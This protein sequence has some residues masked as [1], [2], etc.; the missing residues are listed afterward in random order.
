MAT[1]LRSRLQSTMSS[2]PSASPTIS[3]DKY[4]LPTNAK[5]CHYDLTLWTDLESLEFGGF[6][7]VDLD[8]LQETSTIV[9]NCSNDLKLGT[10]SVYCGALDVDQKLQSAQ[11]AADKELERVTLNFFTALPA[12][13]KAQVKIYYSAMLRGSMNGYY[14]SAW[15]RD[16]KTEYY[17]L[18]H[19][20]PTDARAAFPCW[21]EPL[22]KATWTITMISRS[23]TVN[24][25]NMPAES[26]QAWDSSSALE[27]NL[28][29]LLSTLPKKDVLGKITKFQKTPPMSS[30]LVAFANGPFAH[31]ETKV[32]MPLSG[33]SVPLRVYATPDII[34]QAAFC[35]EVTAKVL[36]LYEKI[37]DIEYP[38]P[39][40]DT[41]AAHDFDIGAMEVGSR[42][43][44][45]RACI[46]PRRR[47]NWGL[48]TGRTSAFMMDPQKADIASRKSIATVQSHEV[49]HMWFGNI[50]T[51]E[52]WDYLYLN[53]GFATLMGEA[54]VLIRVF[55]EWEVNSTFVAGHVHRA[56]VLD[57]KLSSHP[58]EVECPDANFINQIFDG[59]S[60][61]KAA[62]VLRMLSEYI[63]EERFLKGV[64]VY[65][66][67]HLYGNSVTRDLWDGVSAAS[68]EDI[69]HLM[70]NWITKIGFPLIT[71]TE[72]ST[73]IHVRQDRYLNNGTPSADD[74]ETIWNIPLAILTVAEDGQ[75]HVDKTAIL[76]EREKTWAIDTSRTFK[77]NAGTIG[78]YRVSYTPERLAKI[79]TE[80][81]KKDSVFSL[82]DRIGLLCDVS[83][84]SKAGLTQVSSLLTLIDIWRNETNC[85]QPFH[86]LSF[87][88][89]SALDLV[90]V[91]VLNS[92]GGIIRPF[93]ER[94]QIDTSLRAFIR[95][96]FVPLVQRLG[97]EFPEGESVDIIQLR[98]TAILGAIV[99]REESV[100]RELQSRFTDY[101]KTGDKTRIPSDIKKSIFTTAVRYGGQEEFEALLRIIEN[102]ANP[103]ERGAAISSIGCTQDLGLVEELFSY[104]LTKARDQDVVHFCFGLESNPL[105]RPL[106]VNFFKDNYDAFSKRFATNSMLKYL[107]S[108][109]FRG[110]STQQAH[111]DAQD[112]FKDKDTTR[113]SMALS[114]ALETIRA[115][116]AYI[117]RSHHD[118]SSWLTKWE[119]QRSTE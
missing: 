9:L 92:F 87:V 110:L 94:P 105:A 91:S 43:E 35:L 100:N 119:Q 113:Y 93:E 67:D 4:R 76:E 97:Y 61:S 13:S 71:V 90:W 56:M 85:K 63:G 74:N 101:M 37:F 8:I 114:Q 50:T 57:S 95:T 109:C 5:P 18:T 75:V 53:E 118:L 112:F 33:R 103:A 99:G 64:S 10:S 47:Q 96:L 84:L 24:I 117:E 16:G 15:K 108:A 7:T 3:Q 82:S 19:F 25:S 78:F 20:Q 34:H 6:V 27:A 21:D 17:A 107:V 116:I 12:G 55:P 68:G 46:N 51:M 2:D 45:I 62:S 58:I 89:L 52:W 106:L 40:L 77:L 29:V 72:T 60:Y 73:G 36:P 115:R 59:L 65:L 42:L 26:E 104:I 44:S 30:Y 11:I 69:T 48:I 102:P 86:S 23:D 39:K 32:V 83:E 49:A 111:D 54:I 14:K 98:Q 1:A 31:L 88:N 41:L 38:L 66:K 28:S 22:L 70:D 81:A 80:A 79:A